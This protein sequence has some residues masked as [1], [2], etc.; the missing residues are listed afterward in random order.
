MNQGSIVVVTKIN[1]IEYYITS[2]DHDVA[3]II[4]I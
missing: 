1:I 3:I 4:S 2:Y